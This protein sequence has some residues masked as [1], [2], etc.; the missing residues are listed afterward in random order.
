MAV[1]LIKQLRDETG[2]SVMDCKKALE[3]AN[4]DLEAAKVILKEEGLAKADKRADRE[5]KTPILFGYIS[6]DGKSGGVLELRCETDFVAKHEDFVNLGN[7]L[8][9]EAVNQKPTDLANFLTKMIG[10]DSVENTIK[11]VIAKFGEKMEI[12]HF[13]VISTTSGIIANYIHAGGKVGVLIEIGSESNLSI[14]NEVIKSF[15][16]D[17]CMQIAAMNPKYITSN[18]IPSETMEFFK[19]EFSES[20]DMSKPEEIRSKILDGKFAKKYEEICL[21]NQHFIKDDSKTIQALVNEANSQNGIKL[22][23]VK[24]FRYQN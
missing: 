1:D 10:T 7:T 22:E 18:D 2:V 16:K 15:S 4:N 14:E 12:G 20:V 21:M 23:I 17:I 19:K 11:G 3:K 5:T 6:A 9:K 24:F 8:V 13:N